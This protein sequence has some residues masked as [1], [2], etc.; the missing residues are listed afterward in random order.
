[1]ASEASARAARGRGPAAFLSPLSPPHT[2]KKHHAGEGA[3]TPTPLTLTGRLALAL[4]TARRTFS[5]ASEAAPPP[6]AP[7]AAGS[8]AA[9][10]S[11]PG[12]GS[13]AACFSPLGAAVAA[14][15]EALATPRGLGTPQR[16]AGRRASVSF[17][18]AA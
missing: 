5:A 13:K 10:P 7:V 12:Y 3:L 11:P 18:E 4:R 6:A 9:T 8:P 15:M 2:Q 17:A 14:A 1:M 16:E